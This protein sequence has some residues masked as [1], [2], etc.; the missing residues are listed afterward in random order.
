M[1]ISEPFIRRP[2]ATSLL[3]ATLALVGIVAYPLLPIAP[4]PQ[5]DFPTVQVQAQHR[6]SPR[7][8]SAGSA[9]FP[10]SPR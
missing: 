2:I 6:R 9:R 5:V 10:A 7:R 3:M 1:N 8:W 4:L